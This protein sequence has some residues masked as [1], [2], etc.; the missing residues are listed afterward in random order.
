LG[1]VSGAGV[2]V[3]GEVCMKLGFEGWRVL[4]FVFK[5]R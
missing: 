4:L 2:G 5:S 3:G 1:E